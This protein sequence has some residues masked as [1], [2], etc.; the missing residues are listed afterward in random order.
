MELLIHQKDLESQTADHDH[1]AFLVLEPLRKRITQDDLGGTTLRTREQLLK[2]SVCGITA[3]HKKNSTPWLREHK[4]S[5]LCV[6]E[7]LRHKTVEQE[8]HG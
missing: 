4:E 1:G 6:K 7:F 8:A 2:E 3:Y 5:V